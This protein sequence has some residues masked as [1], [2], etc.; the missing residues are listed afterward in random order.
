MLPWRNSA[1]SISLA[2]PREPK[3]AGPS[4]Y[5]TSGRERKTHRREQA[6]S[7]PVKTRTSRGLGERSKQLLDRAEGSFAPIFP[8]LI[9]LEGGR[10]DDQTAED[11]S[12]NFDRENLKHV[13]R[14][15][16]RFSARTRRMPSKPIKCA[17][18]RPPR[19]KVRPLCSY[20]ACFFAFS[21]MLRESGLGCL[22]KVAAIRGVGMGRR[23]QS[24][25]F[26]GPPRKNLLPACIGMDVQ[27][28]AL[29]LQAG[30]LFVKLVHFQLKAPL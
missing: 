15:A 5:S 17:N 2:L 12:L 23:E 20:D 1:G 13:A 6:G 10:W 7:V 27:K 28:G 25:K 26:V 22:D 16:A 19:I 14:D 21:N 4:V 3:L 8:L 18:A 11:L 9:V 29:M 30:M 24:V